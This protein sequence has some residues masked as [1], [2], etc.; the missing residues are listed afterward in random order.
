MDP[1]VL[2]FLEAMECLKL[3]QDQ[4]IDQQI[5]WANL[6]GAVANASM[7][8]VPDSVYYDVGTELARRDAV[9]SRMQT[10]MQK[11]IREKLNGD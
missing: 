6:L 11:K 3:V 7:A 8:A 10:A 9:N 5:F 1:R 2:Y 4:K